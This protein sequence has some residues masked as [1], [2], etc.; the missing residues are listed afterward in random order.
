M[1]SNFDRARRC[2]HTTQATHKHMQMQACRARVN[3]ARACP[4]SDLHL[5]V[6]SPR[7]TISLRAACMHA[8]QLQLAPPSPIHLHASISQTG[9]DTTTAIAMQKVPARRHE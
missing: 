5:L 2:E 7:S 6:P 1:R 4:I 8:M 9:E 3:L